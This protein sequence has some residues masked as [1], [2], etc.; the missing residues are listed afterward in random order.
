MMHD[1]LKWFGNLDVCVIK[2]IRTIGLV[3]IILGNGFYNVR[4]LGNYLN[5]MDNW[6]FGINEKNWTNR[7]M[8]W[9]LHEMMVLNNVWE[10]VP[11]L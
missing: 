2:R 6:R 1:I 7:G 4:T 8:G 5:N 11:D 10:G 3:E 9:I